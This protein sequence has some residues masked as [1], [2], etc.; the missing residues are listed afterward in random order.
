MHKTLSAGLPDGIFFRPKILI[1]V[2]FDGHRMEKVGIF[3]SYLVY[4]K[5]IC[6]VLKPFANFLVIWYSFCRFG[7]LHH[8]KSGNPDCRLC[9]EETKN[10]MEAVRLKSTEQSLFG[11][12]LCSLFLSIFILMRDI[13]MHA[14]LA[15]I[16]TYFDL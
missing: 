9:G 11:D 1:C 8:E 7:I 15:G 3:C 10:E 2:Y 14:Q 4:F 12:R 16:H 6:Y 5:A 13:A